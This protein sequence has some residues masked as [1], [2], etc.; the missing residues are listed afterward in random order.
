M[1]KKENSPLLVNFPAFRYS[2]IAV[3]LERISYTF[4]MHG[5]KLSRCVNVNQP[6]IELAIA[7]LCLSVEVYNIISQSALNEKVV[8]SRLIKVAFIDCVLCPV[9]FL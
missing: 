6:P 5:W 1:F 4:Y 9:T 3:R 7:Q 8:F 2:W